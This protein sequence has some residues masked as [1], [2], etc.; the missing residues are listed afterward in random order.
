MLGREVLERGERSPV[1]VELG[2]G[3]L[4]VLSV[5]LDRARRRVMEL[6]RD[7]GDST[8]VNSSDRGAAASSARGFRVSGLVDQASGCLRP[9]KSSYP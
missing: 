6:P 7:A 2:D 5:E 4:V 1:L 9:S 3:G 8:R